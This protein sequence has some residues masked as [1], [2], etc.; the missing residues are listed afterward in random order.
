MLFV[1]IEQCIN[2][3]GDGLQVKTKLIVTDLDNTLLRRDETISDYTV[4]VFRR[5]REH[6]LL[7]A[8]ATGRNLDSSEDYRVMLNPDGDIV[9][10][11]CLVYVGGRLLVSYHLPE[12]QSS[13]LLVELCAHPQIKIVKACSMT[14]RYSNTPI[15]GRICTDF[16]SPLPEKLIHCSFRTDDV[17]LMTLSQFDILNSF[18]TTEVEATYMIFILKRCLSS[19]V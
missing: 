16:N 10:G 19:T 7:V 11:G 18:F 14:A 8:F 5:V 4:D 15:E 6:G 13:N 2:G 3:I 1:V 12:P 17:G 9:T